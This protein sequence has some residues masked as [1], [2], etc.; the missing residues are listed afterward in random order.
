MERFISIAEHCTGN[1]PALDGV[2]GSA[3]RRL[4]A[5]DKRLGEA[6]H[7]KARKHFA[8]WETS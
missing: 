1:F 3:S 8:E 5:T 7:G 6:W 4:C 2:L